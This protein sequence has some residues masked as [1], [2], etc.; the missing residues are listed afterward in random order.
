[1]KW[2]VKMLCGVTPQKHNNIYE[3]LIDNIWKKKCFT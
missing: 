1:M 2:L 3:L